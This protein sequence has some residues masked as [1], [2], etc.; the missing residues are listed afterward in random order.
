MAA[1]SLKSRKS[2]LIDSLLEERQRKLKSEAS[3]ASEDQTEDSEN[4]AA[5]ITESERSKTIDSEVSI[6]STT[7]TPS[8]MNPPNNTQ[9][10][11]I[12]AFARLMAANSMQNFMLSQT[13]S[14]S[15]SA[16]ASEYAARF[17]MLNL[18]AMAPSLAAFGQ[19]QFNKTMIPTFPFNIRPEGP[20]TNHRLSLGS[21]NHFERL[22]S[23]SSLSSARSSCSSS[24]GS[25]TTAPSSTSTSSTTIRSSNV[26]KYR[27]DI[28]DKTFSRSNTLITHKRIHTGEKPFRCEVCS[29]AFRQPGNLT[30]H[31]LTHTTEKPFVCHE[32]GKAFNRA[33]NL[34]THLRT[35]IQSSIN[36]LTPQQSHQQQQQR[37]LH[38]STCS[39]SF[40]H[41][42][43]LRSH[44]CT[45]KSLIS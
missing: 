33:S 40:I 22:M 31:R 45:G 43:E 11:F 1:A 35:H 14:N 17:R 15:A 26:K 44:F 34:H 27:C 8:P 4:E 5:S 13:S 21:T 20:S 19:T 29:R 6:E 9:I 28:C 38:C 3:T 39:K 10:N 25:I 32:C 37:L 2:F 30:R 12:N 24:A 23:S 41:K 18:N 16:S 36:P 42:S 7:A